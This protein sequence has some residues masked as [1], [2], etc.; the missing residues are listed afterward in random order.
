V[1]GQTHGPSRGQQRAVCSGHGTAQQVSDKARTARSLPRRL[2]CWHPD[3]P[4]DM[5]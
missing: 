1:L 3:I 5:I 4:D 2:S